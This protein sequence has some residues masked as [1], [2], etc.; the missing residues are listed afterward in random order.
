[1]GPLTSLVAA[2][3]ADVVREGDPTPY[4]SDETE[5][6]SLVGSCEAVVLPRTT[7]EVATVVAWAYE[8]D[9]P[10]VPRGGGTGYAGG[11]VPT[12]GS[13]VLSLERLTRVRELTPELWRLHV[14]AGVTT[15]DV[16]RLARENGLYYPP[17]P[18][19]GE[20]SQIGGNIATNAGGPHAFKYGTTRAWVTGIEAVVPPGDVIVVGGPIRKDAAGLDLKDLLIGSEGTLGVVT[21]AW[22]RLIPAPAASWPVLA[23]FDSV[24]NGVEAIEVVLGSGL[25]PAALEF[26]DG[27][28]LEAAPLSFLAE[29][30]R[31][32]FCVLCDADGDVDG[33]ARLRSEL[34]EV[35]SD[36]AAVV[37]AP[38]DAGDSAAIWRW[39]EGMTAAV[40]TERGGKVSEDIVVPLDRLREAIERTR[41]IGDQIGLPSCSWGHAGDGNLHSTFMA[42]RHDPGQLQAARHGAELL[43]ALAIELGGSISGEHGIGSV[44]AGF[45]EQQ[46]PGRPY[47]LHLGIKGLFD[48]KQLLNPGKKI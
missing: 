36:Y 21:A 40:T 3:G 23:L 31:S 12:P 9:V 48:P 41:A 32:D 45:L 15:H 34:I 25:V 22:L 37:H 1:V 39:R 10:L 8:H 2:L 20:Q 29:T 47:Q 13:V 14:E 30:P 16:R 33:A 42:D 46:W 4:L 6:Q 28:A 5:T 35:L 24:A 11:A 18:G 19:A 38:E 26:V 44:K 27:R 7:A 43:F 17:D